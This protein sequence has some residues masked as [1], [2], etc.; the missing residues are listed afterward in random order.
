MTQSVPPR[1]THY[2]NQRQRNHSEECGLTILREMR[3]A[4][5]L[6]LAAGALAACAVFGLFAPAVC[7]PQ[8]P[9]KPIVCAA[10]S[11]H[12]DVR[13]ASDEGRE[14]FC[15]LDLPGGLM[16]K[17]GPF[18]AWLS[19]EARPTQGQY[20]LGREV[21][22]W[23]DCNRFNRCSSI[24]YEE[25]FGE[26]QKRAAFRAEVPVRYEH[27]MYRFDFGSC[28]S[29][30]VT[31]SG[32]AEPVSLN[33]GGGS[34][35]RCVISWIPEHVMEHGGEG[36]YTCFV[37]YAV[38][39]REFATLDLIKE[40]PQAG[41]PQFCRPERTSAEPLMIREGID[42]AAYSLDVQC[43]ALN[44]GR[45][46]TMQVAIKLTPVAADLVARTAA[47]KGPLNT[48]LCMDSLLGPEV[49]REKGGATTFVL[50]LSTD[51]AASLRQQKCVRK[52]LPVLGGCAIDTVRVLH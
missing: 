29:T 24:E 32:G 9:K 23:I 3:G 46:G 47:E 11:I 49:V 8:G 30:W 33:V 43:A 14:E 41:L 1:P 45:E 12:R 40:F 50:K 39:I 34:P 31:Q 4:R 25:V 6:R 35:Y 21:G 15:E 10:G 20:L 22:K 38:G 18:R 37:P 27:G 13:H 44:P 26:E 51:K 2:I 19:P 17:D 7:T 5:Q 36:T 16:V 48:L 42:E 52:N 28:R